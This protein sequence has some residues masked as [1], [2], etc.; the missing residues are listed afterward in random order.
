MIRYCLGMWQLRFFLTS[1]VW[2]DI[3][4]RYRGSLLGLGW[5]MLNPI[6]MTVILTVVFS[7]LFHMPI[8]FYASYVMSGLTIWA[9]LQTSALSGSQCFHTSESYIRQV[10]APMALYPMR[11]V[12][13]NGFHLLPGLV[14]VFTLTSLVHRVPSIL[15]VLSVLPSLVL[16]IMFGWSLATL[17]GLANVRFR[18]TRHLAEV[19]FQALY[20]L[21]PIMYEAKL[22]EGRKVGWIIHFNPLVPFIDLFRTPVLAGTAPSLA[23]YGTA[24]LITLASM[25]LAALCLRA[26][27]KTLIFHL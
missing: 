8:S 5:S 26:Q 7:T 23:L 11:T 12:L 6:A 18:D 17:F 25:G 27:E 15:G 3:R 4:S 13:A 24:A 9:F 20:F 16:L 21:T 22:F 1:V 2:L 19:A 14:L 10:S